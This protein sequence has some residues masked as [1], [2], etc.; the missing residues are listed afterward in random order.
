LRENGGLRHSPLA[1]ASLTEGFA[2]LLIGSMQHCY[3]AQLEQRKFTPV[4]WHVRR[5]VDFM[6]AH[7]GK[8]ITISTVAQSINVSVRALEKGFRTFKGTTPA[9]YL[10]A[11]RVQAARKDLLDP[12]NRQSV[13]AICLKW[14]FFHA[15][16]FSAFYKSVYG[17]TPHATKERQS[18][19]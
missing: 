13:K 3:S 19:K 10:R 8:P 7:I 15:G 4:P 18:R 1:M 12:S 2:H 17:E 9:S 5:A 11:L 14:G 16:R 6:Q